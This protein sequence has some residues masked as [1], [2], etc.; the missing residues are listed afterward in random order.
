MNKEWSQNG[1][2]RKDKSHFYEK[3]IV[4]MSEKERKEEPKNSRLD[5]STAKKL[6]ANFP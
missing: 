6:K 4:W 5:P 3:P 1:A 2:D